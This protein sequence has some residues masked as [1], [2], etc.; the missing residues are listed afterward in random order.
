MK[1]IIVDDTIAV[2]D[3]LIQILASVPEVEIAGTAVSA[4]AAVELIDEQNPAAVILDWSLAESNGMRVLRYV[5]SSGLATKIIVVTN[6]SDSVTRRLCMEAGADYFLDKSF[7]YE[8]IPGI[9][10]AIMTNGQ[11]PLRI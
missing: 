4:K 1:V 7:E 6:Y 5:R 9:L 2:Q 3:R 10:S 11:D 8:R